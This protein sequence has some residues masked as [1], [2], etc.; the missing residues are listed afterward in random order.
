MTTT[1]EDL[2][3]LVAAQQEMI[4]QLRKDVDQNKESIL[5]LLDVVERLDV[6]QQAQ[7]N[8]DNQKMGR[9][10]LEKLTKEAARDV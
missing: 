5:V 6:T 7:L 2:L 10:W 4:D 8:R 9:Q 1:N 3:E